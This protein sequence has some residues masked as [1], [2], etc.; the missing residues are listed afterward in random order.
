MKNNLIMSHE[1]IEKALRLTFKNGI[2]MGINCG[3]ENIDELF[4]LDRGK[5]VVVTGIPNMGKSEFVD[6]LCVQYNKLHG[7][8]T[9]YF[10]PENQPICLHIA[11]LYSKFEGKRFRAEEIDDKRSMAV[12]KYIYDNFL[13]FNYS[14]EYGIEQVLSV[15]EEQVYA[16]GIDILVIDSHNKLLHDTT[17]N[18]TDVISRELD[19]I[20]RFAK[21]L[22]IIVILV[23]HPRK[24]EKKDNSYVIPSAYDINGSANFYNKAD[25]VFTVHRNYEPN[26][27]I[28]KVDKVKFNNYGGQGTIHLGYDLVSG[29]YYNIPDMD[30]P[31]NTTVP[32]PPAVMPFDLHSHEKSGEEWLNISCSCAERVYN[33]TISNCNL[34]SFLTTTTGELQQSIE[35]IR[36]A[37][38]KA[39]MQELK[40]KLLPII[41]PSVVVKDKRDGNHIDK[42]TG[43][44]C[45]DID[46]GDNQQNMDKVLE[47]L[48]SLPYIA[49]AQR[50]ASGEGYYAIIPV[51]YKEC[52]SEHFLAIE[53]DFSA[54]GI[55]VDASCKD[56]VRARYYSYD[57]ERYVNPRCSL[58]SKRMKL[59]NRS[60]S[61]A[62][63]SVTEEN[64]QF[65]SPY[66]QNGDSLQ[67]ELD[68]ICSG[69][70]DKNICPTYQA[71]FEVGCALAKEMGE[72][73]R[74]YFHK[75]SQ[76][77]PSYSK[78]ETDAKFDELLQHAAEYA[79]NRGTIFYYINQA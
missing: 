60:K 32:E 28:I 68:K 77:Y 48:K 9:L 24:M 59:S 22:N 51:K 72:S 8:K 49:F 44:L 4:R 76:G 78:A 57:K 56:S 17:K 26:Y 73:G 79:Y 35:Q 46:K 55:K 20:E 19:S 34:W 21:R 54:M 74:A 14:N 63:V 75:L 15:A 53:C 30:D 38:D 7:M 71:W 65:Y 58:Y 50:S 61:N 52:I 45:I 2:P 5:L 42:Y 31:F 27:A 66:S 23:A 12:R 6:Y 69:I 70:G 11:K 47:T 40:T 3:L 13:F 37:S 64:R 16:K 67:I 18:E 43:L 1:D 33:T 36:S 39:Q 62:N 10:S 29:N 41:T 25:F